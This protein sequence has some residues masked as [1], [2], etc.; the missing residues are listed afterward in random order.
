M[1]KKAEDKVN[2]LAEEIDGMMNKLNTALGMFKKT[3]IKNYFA[4]LEK[5]KNDL[6]V[7]FDTNTLEKMQNI[8]I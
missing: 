5:G 6:P 3:L 7:V 4:A 8:L 1:L 2:A